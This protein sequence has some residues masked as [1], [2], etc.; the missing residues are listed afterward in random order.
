MDASC[1]AKEPIPVPR[2][3]PRDRAL[4]RPLAHERRQPAAAFSVAARLDAF[5]ASAE[6]QT[7]H[8]GRFHPGTLLAPAAGNLRSRRVRR[9]RP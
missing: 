6:G 1:A 2:L 3:P 5:L 7:A 8:D 9:R 4:M